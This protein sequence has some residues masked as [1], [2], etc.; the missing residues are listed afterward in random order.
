MSDQSLYKFESLHGSKNYTSWVIKIKDLLADQELL[1]HIENQDNT[2][3]KDKDK[4]K[5]EEHKKWLKRDHRALGMIHIRI[6]EKLIT[7]V[8]NAEIA[9]KAWMS[10]NDTFGVQGL[11]AMIMAKRKVFRAECSETDDMEQHLHSIHNTTD[12][13]AMLDCPIP[14]MDLTAAILMSLPPSYD[15]LID[16]LDYTKGSKLDV[17]HIITYIL[18]CDC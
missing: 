8:K 7:Y 11:S 10:L 16:L 1:E 3:D 13:L 18:K 4:D 14:D 6:S 15:S 5:T 2:K 9:H 17:N 12:D